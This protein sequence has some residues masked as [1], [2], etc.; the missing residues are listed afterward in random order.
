MK[1][2]SLFSGCGGLD[3]GFEK[4]G[5][6]IVFSNDN[7]QNLWETYTK[8]HNLPIDGRS[9]TEIESSEI[10]DAEG[11]IGGP[12]CQSWSLA[13]AM[14]G[15][16]DKRGKLFLEYIRVLS[17]K[18]PK[19]FVAENV[20]GILS[21]THLPDF[22]KIIK[23]F[24]ELRY[25]VSYENIKAKNYGVPQERDRVIIVGYRKDLN[26]KFSFPQPTHSKDGAKGTL[27]W[28]TL[29][30]AIADLPKAIP[31]LEKNHT[32]PDVNFPNHE[33]MNG[34]FS[35]I[36]M[37]RNRKKNWDQQSYTIQAGGRH[38][39]LHPDSSVMRK[40]DTDE[41]TF[42]DENP[43]FRRLTVRECARIQTFPDDFVFFYERIADG[44]KMVGNAVPVKLAECIAKKIKN[45]FNTENKEEYLNQNREMINDI[46]KKG[47]KT[48]TLMDFM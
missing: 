4:Q 1:I 5:F 19:F 40:I 22:L 37:S 32:N 18:N 34:S 8:N 24:E 35:S 26:I 44:Y 46:D 31:A 9:I 7:Y 41:W 25:V 11:I 47:S 30:D 38:A 2:I 28:V 17:D 13:G 45:D 10:P 14:G 20:P 36:F 15:I 48:G 6:E 29:K 42:V 21:K 16:K 39:P 23:K 27:K 3:L 33:Y 12:P 43:F